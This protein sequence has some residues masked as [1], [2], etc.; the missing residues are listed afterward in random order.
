M[1]VRLGIIGDTQGHYSVDGLV[2]Q[3]KHH[4]D[5]VNP[6]SADLQPVVFTKT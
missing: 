4:F 6:G 5:S 1:A 2:E 3:V